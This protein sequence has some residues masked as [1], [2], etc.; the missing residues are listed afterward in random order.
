MVLDLKICNLTDFNK[1]LENNIS[2]FT[3]S[4]LSYHP[5]YF[6]E[7]FP[8]QFDHSRSTLY[9]MNRLHPLRHCG[10]GFE[11][12]MDV[13]VRFFLFVLSCVQ[14]EDLR[15]ADRPSKESN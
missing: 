8:L 7:Q 1:S 13:C 6:A 9:G 2:I 14:V 5:L 11:S 10:R 4:L 3:I 15:R 12:H